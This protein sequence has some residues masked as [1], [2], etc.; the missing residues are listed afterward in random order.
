MVRN[1]QN[2]I[3]DYTSRDQ[4]TL[5]RDMENYAK[6]YYSDIYKN[7]S[8]NSFGSMVMDMVSYY[9]DNLS[10]YLDYQMNEGILDNAQEFDNIIQLGKQRGYKLRGRP[11]SFGVQTFYI[12]IPALIIGQGPDFDY[13]PVLKQ[14]SQ[15]ASDGGLYTVQE[16]IYFDN[17]NNDIVVAEVNSST[18]APTYFA[19]KSEGIVA[20]GEIRTKQINIGEFQRFLKVSFEDEDFSEILSVFDSLGNRYYE[21]DHLSQNIIYT[22]VPNIGRDTINEPQS[23]LRPKIV[24]R[25]F[26]VD[27]D[28]TNVE[29]QFGAGN[30][31]SQ[32]N[33]E[34]IDPDSV[35]LERHGKEYISSFSLDPTKQILNDKFGVVPTNTTLF[36]TY[37]ANT[38]ITSN[39]A[40]GEVNRIAN[41][42]LEFKNRQNQDEAQ[43]FE[44]IDSL[45]T[46]NENP[47][48]GETQDLNNEETKI[49][50]YG[51]NSAQQRAVTQHDYITTLYSLPAMYGSV[52]RASAL[53]DARSRKRNVNIYVVSEDVDGNLIE[54][55]EVV[56]QNA[57]MWLQKYKM[58]ND[59]V[60]ILDAKIVNYAIEFEFISDSNVNKFEVLNRV[61]QELEQE[62]QMKKDIGEEISISDLKKVINRTEG[63]VDVT[64][65]KIINR[66]GGNYST[67]Y[68]D[69]EDM[70]SDDGR[71]IKCPKNCIF[72]LKYPESDIIG[73]AK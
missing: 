63:V 52:K 61:V 64:N 54:T 21:V 19:V 60:D 15:V 42:I 67:V 57:K 24:P 8:E 3:V 31:A 27:F 68:L 45:E 26:V 65:L 38:D 30:G 53:Q 1:N 12:K 29:L 73:I 16:D 55:S 39:A 6:N 7:F 20:S 72:E 14:G 58:I 51:Q 23:L 50:I 33:D 17:L 59:T 70:M 56:K 44:V 34:R 10:F 48:I 13:L 35:M 71:Y 32:N 5:K 9:G 62:V 18:G 66:T 47:I 4:Q 40:V 41:P 46:E 2:R 22:S 43:I 37:R 11:L 49:K 36:I 28:R 69:F 25:R